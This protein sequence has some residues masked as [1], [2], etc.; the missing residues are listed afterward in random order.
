MKH[1]KLKLDERGHGHFYIPD[2][3]E[4]LVEMEVS[5]DGNKLAVL[6]TEVVSIAQGK[7]LAKKLLTTMVRYARKN[8][9]KVIALCAFVNMQFKRHPEKYADVWDKD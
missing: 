5:F 8:G 3:E 2:G 6:H 7:G 4:E 9:L 1:V